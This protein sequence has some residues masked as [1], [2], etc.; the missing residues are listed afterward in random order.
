MSLVCIFHREYNIQE[1][2]ELIKRVAELLLHRHIKNVIVDAD[3][4]N[5]LADF[6][7]EKDKAKYDQ[8]RNDMILA[9][10][11]VNTVKDFIYADSNI[12]D[13]NKKTIKLFIAPTTSGV[14][15]IQKKLTPK[16]YFSDNCYI[17]CPASQ[18]V[19]LIRILEKFTFSKDLVEKVKSYKLNPVL[20]AQLELIFKKRFGR[21]IEERGAVGLE[22]PVFLQN[23]GHSP[24]SE[25]KPADPVQNPLVKQGQHEV[26]SN[27]DNELLGSPQTTIRRQRRQTT[28]NKPGE[29]NNPITPQNIT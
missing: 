9:R 12:E 14:D 26:G 24:N 16:E 5:Q 10:D 29:F 25:I 21:N 7:D 6:D 28:Q 8:Y 17:I 3:S 13:H 23:G 2:A 1:K 27:N 15:Q 18:L 22:N 19:N 11:G 20:K 4:N